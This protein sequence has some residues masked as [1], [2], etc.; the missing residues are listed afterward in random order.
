VPSA[1]AIE[2]FVEGQVA[3]GSAADEDDLELAEDAFTRALALR[4]D[5]PD[6]YFQR[7]LVRSQL[8]LYGEGGPVGSEG[9]REDFERAVAL[10]PLNPLAWNNLAGARF[11]L[12]LSNLNL[13]LFLLF[14]GDA[15][16]YRAQLS[17]AEEIFGRG[18][19]HR[20]TRAYHLSNLW[21]ELN[22]VEAYRPEYAEA[23][24]DAREDLLRLDHQ[25]T[26]AAEFFG[27]A[28]PVPVE[29]EVSRLAFALSDD[30][31]ELQVTFDA[32]G[33]VA[34]QRWLWR[35]YRGW[36]EDPALSAVPEVWSFGVPDGSAV[37]TLTLADGFEAGVPVRV[38][39]FFEG[40]LL[41]AGEYGA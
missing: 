26:V 30:R 7:G 35:T 36:V 25:L 11:W 8:D 2:A 20:S 10:D 16:G 32:T 39:I 6:A 41:Q 12:G 3:F 38:E 5:Y 17:A 31:T 22:L 33:V 27:T 13:A 14:D 28:L 9:A 24:R 18:D 4:S 19:V 34:G 29:A 21:G 23:A 37:I 15:S 1:E 40:N